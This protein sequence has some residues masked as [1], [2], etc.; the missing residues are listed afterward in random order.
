MPVSFQDIR[1]AFDFANTGRFGEFQ[2]FLCKRT[3]KIYERYEFSDFAEFND[4]LPDDIEDEEK[5]I[6]LPDKHELGLGKPLALS[7]ARECLPDDFDETRYIFSKRGAYP[8]FKALLARRNATD[9]WYEFEAKATDE[10]LR[11]WCE[12]NSIDLVE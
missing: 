2:A 12:L 7:F 3:G 8:K 4:E 6:A 5:Y 9:R 11:E 10:A 1:N